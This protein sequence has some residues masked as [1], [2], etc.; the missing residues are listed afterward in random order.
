MFFRRR[1]RCG[2]LVGAQITAL[3]RFGP[4]RHVKPHGALYTLAARDAA[5]AK[6]VA[7]TVHAADSSLILFGLAGSELVKAG[8]AAGLKV[9]EEVF[10]DRTYQR[11]GS[12]TPRSQPNALITNEAVAVAQVLRMVREGRV[13]ATDGADVAIKP[14]R[15]VFMATGRMRWPLRGGSRRNW[16]ARA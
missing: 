4:L 8:R 2:S 1:L 12:L 15:C 16:P 9:A 6:V 5:V 7:K 11:G 3:A 10:A 13:C 14:T